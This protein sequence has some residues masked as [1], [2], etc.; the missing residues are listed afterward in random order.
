[1][2]AKNYLQPAAKNVGLMLHLFCTMGN[3]ANSMRNT[4]EGAIT[5]RCG[6]HSV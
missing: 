5:C 6:H 1:M 3:S 2:G 4:A